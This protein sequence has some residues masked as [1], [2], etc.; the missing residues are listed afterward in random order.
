VNQIRIGMIG[1]G[2]IAH[3]H[4][5]R[6]KGVPEAKI[7]AL[8]DPSSES[9]EQIKNKFS[10]DLPTFSDYKLMLDS[11]ELDAVI[12][13]SP[14][15]CHADQVLDSLSK[16]L[17]VHV[18]KPMV[19]STD[20]AYRVLERLEQTGKVLQISYQ[21]H[22]QSQFMYMRQAIEEGKI[23]DIKF[24]SAIQCQEWLLA[25]KGTWRQN[26]LLGGG[27]QLNDS[28]S[29]LI[30][31]ILWMTG[32]TPDEVYATIDNRGS[33]VDINS[34][35]SVTFTSGAKANISI[36]GD[37]PCWWEDITI[38]GELGGFFYRNGQLTLAMNNE[39]PVV[40]TDL[41]DGSDPDKNFINTI[42]GRETVDA[43]AICGLRVIE[44]SE[45]AWKSAASG[46]PEKVIHR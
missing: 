45:A 46:Q 29:H 6:L 19:C 31:I 11:V 22:Q 21:R 16:G 28:G 27:G 25:T 34:A 2:G 38:T 32:L 26:P 23:G 10:L 40:L 36:V 9:I 4:V 43:P 42:L 7:V 8:A 35:I 12:I 14:H 30:D 24:I 5:E 44:L 18:Q 3:W 15:T 37:S 41:P 20:D 33:E 17:H 39:K 1:T 13:G